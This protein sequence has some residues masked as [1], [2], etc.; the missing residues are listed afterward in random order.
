MRQLAPGLGEG[1]EIRKR[2]HGGDAREFLA[3]VVGVAAAAVE[4]SN[5][6]HGFWLP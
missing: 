6:T 2:L 1:A 3:E 5:P 4:Y